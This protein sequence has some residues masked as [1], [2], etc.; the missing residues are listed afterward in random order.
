MFLVLLLGVLR[1]H[2]ASAATTDANDQRLLE[3]SPVLGG[4]LPTGVI[5]IKPVPYD[6]LQSPEFSSLLSTYIE[7]VASER[8]QTECR[9][10]LDIEHFKAQTATAAKA[11]PEGFMKII[12]H[13]EPQAQYGGDCLS[14]NKRFGAVL[15]N[16]A[17][18]SGESPTS[19]VECTAAPWFAEVEIDDVESKESPQGSP[20]FLAH[21]LY[22]PPL[23]APFTSQVPKALPLA[24]T[25]RAELPGGLRPPAR[26]DKATLLCLEKGQQ[27]TF[28]RNTEEAGPYLGEW[29][30]H[31]ITARSARRLTWLALPQLFTQ[32]PGLASQ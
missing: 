29:N 27:L 11:G 7:D 30:C 6:V 1:P 14:L 22:T 8:R 15:K 20:Y 9:L 26:G 19:V 2:V 31:P 25:H 18:P 23:P 17:S 4:G 32:T 16:V 5:E 3:A 24:P 21:L 28:I 12:V 10:W 13:A